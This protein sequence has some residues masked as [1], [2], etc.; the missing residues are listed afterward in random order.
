MATPSQGRPVAAVERALA[1]LEILAD[2]PDLGVNEIARRLDVSPSSASRLL[3]T[4]A[5]HGLV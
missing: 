5:G 1:V 2:A 3:G 4:L